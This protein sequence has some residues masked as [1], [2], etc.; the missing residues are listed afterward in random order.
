LM[1][2]SDATSIEVT[3]QAHDEHNEKLEE[4]MS[5]LI[6]TYDQRADTYYRNEAGRIILP[7][8]FLPE[9]YWNMSQLPD[10]S[11]FIIHAKANLE[12]AV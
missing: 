9:D 12:G 4:A 3:Q 5:K 8:P 1:V 11:K 10:A 7:S 6:W 2:E